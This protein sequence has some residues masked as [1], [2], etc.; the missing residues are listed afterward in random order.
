MADKSI[1]I[2]GAGA[3]DV[4][5]RLWQT[6]EP[7]I[8]Y[9]LR[10]GV[11]G[12][13]ADSAEIRSLQA[14]IR[15]SPRVQ[16]LLAERDADGRTPYHPY[17]KWVG[18]HWLLA[19]LAD[20]GY[21]PGDEALIPLREQTLDWLLGAQHTRSIRALN[22][23]TR[24]CAS[25]ESN[26]LFALLRLGLADA[27]C[28]ELAERLCRWQ[29]PDGGWNCDRRPEAS[30]SSF[31][32]SLIPLRALAWY[33]RLTG[34]AASEATVERAAEMVLARR[35]VPRVGDGQVIVPTFIALHYPC[36]W[37]YDALFGLKVLAEAGLIG[38]PRCAEALDWL[39]GRQLPGGGWPADA[40]FYRRAT[41]GS[42][43]SPVSWGVVGPKHLNEW[44]SAD[45]LTVLVAAGRLD[46]ASM[47]LEDALD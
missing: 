43:R 27:R 22:G 12:E 39:E 18:A 14:Q 25:Q 46:G 45:S 24:R 1:I 2:I 10:T 17:T 44:V 7:A 11:W 21:P 26:A 20:I 6:A 3:N 33:A 37:H 16:T 30:H 40:R 28:D 9:K 4:I 8:R 31:H 47:R 35:L 15:L 19:T 32:E 36:Y 41:E 29:W 38:D 42:G 5:S 23:R 34:H 13:G